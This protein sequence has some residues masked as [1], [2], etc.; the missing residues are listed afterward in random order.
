MTK[1][2]TM[3]WHFRKRPFWERVYAQTERRGECLIFT[4]SKDDFGY[5]RINKGNRQLVRVH[6]AVWERDNGPIPHKMVIM[7]TCDVRACIEPS[8]LQL[9]TQRENVLDRER[10]GR[11]NHMIRAQE[12]IFGAM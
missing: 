12:Y 4:G 8:H 3:S 2:K 9:G 11:G 10:K 7:H 5:G 6:R 1:I